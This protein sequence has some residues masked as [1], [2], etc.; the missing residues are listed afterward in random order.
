MFQAERPECPR[1]WSG[2]PV[3]DAGWKLAE[4]SASDGN[5]VLISAAPESSTNPGRPLPAESTKVGLVS[6]P[7]PR[8]PPPRVRLS[9]PQ[10][11]PMDPPP[12]VIEPSVRDK[13]FLLGSAA[14]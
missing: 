12:P 7:P 3:S 14:G 10:P 11:T 2:S 6:S 4:A 9:G 8:P 5:S 1:L 13:P